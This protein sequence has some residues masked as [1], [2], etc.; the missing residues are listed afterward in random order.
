MDNPADNL[1]KLKAAQGLMTTFPVTALSRG[2]FDP[3]LV[4]P[5]RAART[6]VWQRHWPVFFDVT[7]AHVITPLVGLGVD[8]CIPLTFAP[9]DDDLFA[10]V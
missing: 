10:V 8:D 9:T 1:A 6:S 5:S 2:L 3:S 4:S 7:V